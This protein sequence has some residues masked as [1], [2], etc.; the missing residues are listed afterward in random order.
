MLIKESDIPPVFRPMPTLVQAIAIIGQLAHDPDIKQKITS[1]FS[2]KTSSHGSIMKE[3]DQ[4]ELIKI[5]AKFLQ[6]NQTLGGI[7]FT[8][9]ARLEPLYFHVSEPCIPNI[10]RYSSM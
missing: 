7:T 6:P 3:E 10:H 1:T 2:G 5:F 4:P 9:E 8:S